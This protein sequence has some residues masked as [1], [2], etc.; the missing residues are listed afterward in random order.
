MNYEATLLFYLMAGISIGVGFAQEKL[1]PGVSL[2]IL[3]VLLI[4]STK[5]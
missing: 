3:G 1:G 2:L 4:W 5:L